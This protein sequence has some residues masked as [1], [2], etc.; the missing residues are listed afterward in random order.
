V[1]RSVLL[2]SAYI[3]FAAANTVEVIAMEE[4]DRA[5]DEKSKHVRTYGAKDA[6]GEEVEYLAEF[7]GLTLDDLRDLSSGPVL[8]YMDGGRIPYTAI[9]DPHDLSELEHV[10]GVLDAD[11][12]I[13][14]VARH[15]KALTAKHGEGIDR[16]LWNRVTEGSALVDVHLGRGALPKAWSIARHL[17][18]ITVRCPVALTQR[19]D[20]VEASVLRDVDKRIDEIEKQAAESPK[21]AARAALV[22]EV[23]ELAR[24]FDE[25][26][27]A[28]RLRALRAAL[29]E[30]ASDEDKKPGDREAPEKEPR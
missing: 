21:A 5:V 25:A 2:D 23:A 14:R 4:L 30:R 6:A 18:S 13:K 8:R 27:P 7:P 28:P 15:R 20:A 24:V 22:R 12:L 10:K 9:V 11:D 3:R 29:S 19:V 17:R 1:H 26:A 16:D